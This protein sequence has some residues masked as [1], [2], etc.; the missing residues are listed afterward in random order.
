M[1]DADEAVRPARVVRR[2]QLEHHLLLG[3]ELQLLEVPVLVQI[4]HVQRVAVLAGRAAA[5]G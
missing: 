4:P 3:A 2:A 5:R 1:H